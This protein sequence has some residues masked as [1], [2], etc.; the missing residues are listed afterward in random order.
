MSSRYKML[1][2]T[3]PSELEN[4]VNL[5]L[6]DGYT[7]AQPMVVANAGHVTKLIQVMIKYEDSA[8]LNR[9]GL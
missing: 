9:Y 6:Q 1:V 7:V 2:D 5:Y 8:L 3:V 4:Q